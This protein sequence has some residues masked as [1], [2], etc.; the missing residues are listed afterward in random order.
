[1]QA[2]WMPMA[3]SWKMILIVVAGVFMAGF[4]DGIAGGGGIVSC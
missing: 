3:L 1:M 2:M 4:M